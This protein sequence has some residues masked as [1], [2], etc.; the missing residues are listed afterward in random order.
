M[1]RARSEYENGYLLVLEFNRIREQHGANIT[2]VWARHVNDGSFWQLIE[3]QLAGL[4][5]EREE[6]GG[7]WCRLRLHLHVLGAGTA[8]QLLRRR[9][10]LRREIEWEMWN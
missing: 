2:G 9:H 7:R 5:V 1:K 4:I 10:R 6:G 8:H 3:D